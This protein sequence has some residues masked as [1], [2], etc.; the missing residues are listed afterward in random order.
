MGERQPMK[1]Q[2]LSASTSGGTGVKKGTE[3][4]FGENRNLFIL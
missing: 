1:K 2:I 3:Q 4:N